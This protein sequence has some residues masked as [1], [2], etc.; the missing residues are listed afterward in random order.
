MPPPDKKSGRPLDWAARDAKVTGRA[1][2]AS[3]VPRELTAWRCWTWRLRHCCGCGVPADCVLLD[4]LPVH[5]PQRCH[6]AEFTAEGVRPC[7]R[8]AA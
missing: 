8:D 6:G 1:L 7:C 2:D 5:P 3:T 4:P